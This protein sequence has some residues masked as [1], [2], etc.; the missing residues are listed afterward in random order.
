MGMQ[1]VAPKRTVFMILN[2]E[3]AEEMLLELIKIFNLKRL[4]NS[5][6][7]K[8]LMHELDRWSRL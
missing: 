3:T 5:P 4:T 8:E 7:L 1:I 2:T 6:Q